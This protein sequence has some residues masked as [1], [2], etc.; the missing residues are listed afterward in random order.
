MALDRL[1]S[2]KRPSRSQICSFS[3][4]F[5]LPNL[6]PTRTSQACDCL[7]S[8]PAKRSWLALA[9]LATQT[10]SAA[11]PRMII[12]R[13]PAQASPQVPPVRESFQR[14]ADGGG[15]APG[16]GAGRPDRHGVKRSTRR[17]TFISFPA[18]SCSLFNDSWG[19]FGACGMPS[20]AHSQVPGINS[21]RGWCS[22]GPA[23][24]AAT[25]L[26]LVPTIILSDM[27]EKGLAGR[28]SRSSRVR[29]AP[30]GSHSSLLA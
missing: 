16:R 4:V 22:D 21:A 18:R 15:M 26:A 23:H 28:A 9:L 24:D 20:A 25:L 13:S 17:L 8:K 27:P 14:R 5:N 29:L 2:T 7:R 10:R 19:C 3:P 30:K 11:P 1:D 6:P 12:D